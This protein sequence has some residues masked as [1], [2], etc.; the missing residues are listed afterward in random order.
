[1][2]DYNRM[3]KEIRIQI[4]LQERGEKSLFTCAGMSKNRT[5]KI[6]FWCCD[7]KD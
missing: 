1:M 4:K 7:Y 5:E 6:M 3:G 2:N